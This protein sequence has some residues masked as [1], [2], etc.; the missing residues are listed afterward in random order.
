MKRDKKSIYYVAVQFFLFGLFAFI[1]PLLRWSFPFLFHV[2]GYLLMIMG[3]LILFMA[4]YNLGSN[5]S[6]FPRPKANAKLVTRGIYRYIRHPIYTAILF[7]AFGVF[8]VSGALSQLLIYVLLCILFW[9][10]SG[11]EEELLVKKFPD[12]EEYKSTSGRFFPRI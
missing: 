4:F 2:G 11:Y 12:Y 6:P 5:L 9:Y 8:L 7:G 3:V 10:K 1:P